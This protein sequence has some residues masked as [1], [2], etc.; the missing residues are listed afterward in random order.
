MEVVNFMREQGFTFGGTLD[1]E[2]KGSVV[3]PQLPAVMGPAM[4]GAMSGG[5]RVLRADLVRQL[6]RDPEG[7][8]LM[9]G[10]EQGWVLNPDMSIRMRLQR[11]FRL[12]LRSWDEP[13]AP[14]HFEGPEREE[15]SVSMMSAL[16]GAGGGGLN[17]LAARVMGNLPKPTFSGSETDWKAFSRDWRQYCTTIQQGGGVTDR[18]L[19]RLLKDSLDEASRNTLG[20]RLEE[21]PDLSYTEFWRGLEQEFGRDMTVQSRRAWEKV[22]LGGA[23]RI[24]PEMWRKFTSLFDLRLSQVEYVTDEEV[25]DRLMIELP[26]ELRV[27]LKQEMLRKSEGQFWVRILEPIPMSV[28]ELEEFM[29]RLLRQPT[30]KITKGRKG[31]LVNCGSREGQETLKVVNGWVMNGVVLRVEFHEARMSRQDIFRW[32]DSQLR[33]LEGEESMRE[34]VV[35]VLEESEPS[36]GA[37]EMGVSGQSRSGAVR[38]FSPMPDRR[39]KGKSGK[40]EGK[41]KGKKGQSPDDRGRSRSRSP[42]GRE[43]VKLPSQE[44]KSDKNKAQK[45]SAVQVPFEDGYCYTCFNNGRASNHD[46]KTCQYWEARKKWIAS[47]G[48]GGGWRARS[49]TPKGRGGRGGGRGGEAQE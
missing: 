30:V 31:F 6:E 28:P 18:D 26:S 47:Q 2:R 48:K 49:A 16:T 11:D 37:F 12:Y 33:L 23:K 8:V 1:V 29:A 44:P 3:Y 14:Q 19:L 32:V 45:E 21:K 20:A 38:S 17:P 5:R 27:Q 13:F 43:S 40:G 24:T 34:R 46:F 15:R 4:M 10:Y 42:V 22:T 36:A 9:A 25:E 7:R 41:D 35:R 39:E